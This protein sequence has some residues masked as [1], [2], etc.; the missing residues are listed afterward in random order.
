MYFSCCDEQHCTSHSGCGGSRGEL[1]F[2]TATVAS[3]AKS[4]AFMYLRL[5]SVIMNPYKVLRWR[6]CSFA[7]RWCVIALLG[8][9]AASP[10]YKKNTALSLQLQIENNN[11]FNVCFKC[12][13]RC[14][15]EHD[16]ATS[17]SVQDSRSAVR[18]ANM[19][20]AKMQLR[21]L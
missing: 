14:H 18:T 9:C 11:I 2:P 8:S 16:R 5:L 15:K 1:H 3:H 13:E 4:R 6:D 20:P 17:V 19:K 10:S 7:S 21:A 12:T